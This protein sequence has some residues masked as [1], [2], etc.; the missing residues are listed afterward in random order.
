MILGCPVCC[1]LGT[2]VVAGWSH[3]VEGR[4]RTGNNSRNKS[5]QIQGYQGQE[6]LVDAGL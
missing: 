2:V 6:T 5:R 4:Y 3:W 1:L